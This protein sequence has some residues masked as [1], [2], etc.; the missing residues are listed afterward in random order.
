MTNWAKVN[1]NI[2]EQI[3]VVS[4]DIKDPKKWLKQRFG[5]EWIQLFQGAGIG[6]TYDQKNNRFIAPQPDPSWTFDETE[7]VWLPPVEEAK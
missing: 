4:D 1:K 2:V 3:L 7:G 5:G 6:H